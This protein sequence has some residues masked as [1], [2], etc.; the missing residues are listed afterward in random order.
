MRMQGVSHGHYLLFIHILSVS[1]TTFKMLP[2]IGCQ[3]FAEHEKRALK[4]GTMERGASR[5]H[6][7]I[8]PAINQCTKTERIQRIASGF[9]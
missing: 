4:T 7:P 8:H 2:Q 9:R 3:W 1:N 6:Y 5:R